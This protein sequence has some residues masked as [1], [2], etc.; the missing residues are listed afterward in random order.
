MGKVVSKD[1]K[2]L[3]ERVYSDHLLALL[4]KSR[5]PEFRE[6]D[7][8]KH[9]GPGGGPIPIQRNANLQLLTDEELARVQAIAL[10]LKHRSTEL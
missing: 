1:G 9:S 8:V 5:L 7:S 6:K 3:T 10:R 2:P 4:A